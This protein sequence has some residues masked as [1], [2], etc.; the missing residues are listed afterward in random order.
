MKRS[1]W[2]SSY[3][4]PLPVNIKTVAWSPVANP[5]NHYF[6]CLVWWLNYSADGFK[7]VEEREKRVL[8]GKAREAE[9][10]HSGKTSVTLTQRNFHIS[11]DGWAPLGV[12]VVSTAL[13]RADVSHGGICFSLGV[14]LFFCPFICSTEVCIQRYKCVYEPRGRVNWKECFQTIS[15]Q[16]FSTYSAHSPPFRWAFVAD[17]HRQN[18]WNTVYLIA[19][20]C[21]LVSLEWSEWNIAE[22]DST[23][24]WRH[25]GMGYPFS[26]STTCSHIPAAI[27]AELF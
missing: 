11:L 12:L 17:A 21:W 10:R 26:T 27:R 9:I 7:W 14:N 22:R 24:W 16:H 13:T 3:L 23:Y 6:Y 1:C 8:G 5:S 25:D 18:I 4:Q 19:V 2:P 20:N 15:A